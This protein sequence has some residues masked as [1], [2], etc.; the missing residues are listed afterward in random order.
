MDLGYKRALAEEGQRLEYR[1]SLAEDVGAAFLG[2][3]RPELID[4]IDPLFHS[5]LAKR[6]PDVAQQLDKLTSRLLSICLD[7]TMSVHITD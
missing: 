2:V 4:P 6:L 3:D 7:N 1:I 5:E